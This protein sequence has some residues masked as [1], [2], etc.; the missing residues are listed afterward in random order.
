MMRSIHNE[1]FGRRPQQS[2]GLGVP[3]DM[4]SQHRRLATQL[5]ELRRQRHTDEAEASRLTPLLRAI[6]LARRDRDGCMSPRVRAHRAHMERVFADA[7][8]LVFSVVQMNVLLHARG[9]DDADPIVHEARRVMSRASQAV[10]E[11]SR[12]ALAIWS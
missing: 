3:V 1:G 9:L 4:H 8:D 5:A 11:L 12:A 7:E 2:G 6:L 10:D